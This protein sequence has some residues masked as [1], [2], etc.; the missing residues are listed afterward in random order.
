MTSDETA[1]A[2]LILAG[3]LARRMGGGHK[4]LCQVGGETVLGRLIDRVRP[5]VTALAVNVNADS[6]LF[7]DFGL[8]LIADDL[9]GFPGPLAG[10]LAGLE[11]LAREDPALKWLLTVPGDAPFIPT[12]L[13]SR[14]H[15][16]RRRQ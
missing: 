8:P 10:V 2:G 4:M 3:G 6:H 16:E 9:P 12:G 14:L 7:A 13:V 15:D 11:W 1:T 5:Q